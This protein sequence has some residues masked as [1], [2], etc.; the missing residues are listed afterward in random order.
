MFS[1]KNTWKRVFDF[2]AAS[3][4]ILVLSPIFILVAVVSKCSGG[5]PVVFRQHRVGLNFAPFSLYKF[6]TMALPS[7]GNG[8]MIT[9]QGDKRVTRWGRILR[10][11]KLDELPQMINVL[12]GEMSFVGPRPEVEHYVKLFR[13]D[14]ALILSIRPGITDYAAIKH[15]NEETEL[16]GYQNPEEGYVKEI[17]PEKIKLYKKYISKMG[18]FTDIEIIFL[19]LKKILA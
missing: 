4:G 15:S 9:V 1:Y 7:S 12:K 5:G 18:F 13:E 11:T 2:L 10:R 19:T 14:Y 6:R 17:L 16:A 8:P 3:V